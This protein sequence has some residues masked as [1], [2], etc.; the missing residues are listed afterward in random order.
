ML[1][2][3]SLLLVLMSFVLIWTWGYRYYSNADDNKTGA[4]AVQLDSAS[5]ANHIRDS[6][7]MVY[8]ETLQRLDTQLDSTLVTSDSIKA[9]LEVKLNEFFRLSNE[10]KALLKEKGSNRNFGIAKQKIGELQNKVEDLKDKNQA[11]DTETK[12]M[13]TILEQLKKQETGPEKNGK[14]VNSQTNTPAE[15]F[16]NNDYALFYASDVRLLAMVVNT[17]DE[18]ETS[19][20]DRTS[21]L[22]GSFTVVNNISQMSHVEMMVVV[23]QPDG[24]VL[25]NSEWDAGSFNTPD[26]KKVYS[27]KLSFSY[28]KGEQKRLSFSLKTDKYQKGNYTMQVYFNGVMIGKTS[29]TLS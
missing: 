10:I 15:K 28:S 27:Y 17:D 18:A 20:A 29:R 22:V 21:K 13:S 7:Q 2:L 6:L 1:L 4:R 8:D 5:I 11:V 24:K 19:T 23:L 16:T 12:S 14:Q 26:G 3:V 25:K 9:Q